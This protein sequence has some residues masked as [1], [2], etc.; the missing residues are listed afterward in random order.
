[1]VAAFGKE[2]ETGRAGKPKSVFDPCSIRGRNRRLFGIPF[3]AATGRLAAVCM[4]CLVPWFMGADG[5]AAK[6]LPPLLRARAMMAL[7]A[8]VVLGIGLVAGVILG[9]RMVRRL[10]RQRT[11]PSGAVDDLWYVKPLVP[12]PADEVEGGKPD[13]DEP[14]AA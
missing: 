14:E 3:L 5:E 11:T 9:G 2:Q 4:L 8:L 1:M 13:E 6:P 7:L 10:A 12:A